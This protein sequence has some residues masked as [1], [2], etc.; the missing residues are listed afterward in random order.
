[1]GV[2][3]E[4]AV[5]ND[6]QT[7]KSGSARWLGI[8]PR[9]LTLP[10]LFFLTTLLLI[11]PAFFLALGDINPYDEAAYINSGRMLL[12]GNFP[13]Y[14]DNP[15]VDVFYAL[16]YLPFSGSPYWLVQSAS[17]GRLLLFSLLWVSLYLVGR[18]LSD[19]TALLIPLGIFLVSP[20]AVEMLRFPSDPLF[21][22]FAGLTFC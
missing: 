2:N 22:G 3:T 1:M 8:F 6:S 21:A 15:L 20:L 19:R 4:N 5:S 10:L 7:P 18:R 17:L 11:H 16:T 12:N 14:A 13:S 9:R